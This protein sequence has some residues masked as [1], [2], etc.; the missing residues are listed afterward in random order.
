MQPPAEPVPLTSLNFPPP[1]GSFSLRAAL[2]AA[3]LAGLAIGIGSM[4]PLG[5][6]WI[7]LVIGFGGALSV[8]IYKRRHPSELQMR[9]VD[10]GKLGALASL[11]GYILFAIVTLTAFVLNGAELRQELVKRVHE[12]Q[13]PNPQVQ[14]MYQQLAQKLGTPEGLA[15]LVTFGLAFMF[16][17]FL[18]LGATGGALGATFMHRNRQQ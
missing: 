15:L 3:S 18:I 16:F 10:G 11:F 9:A 1:P 7:I 4:V 8:A 12:M 2:P 14:E 6:A 5:M 13:N 17:F